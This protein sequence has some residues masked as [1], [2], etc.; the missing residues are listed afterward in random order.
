MWRLCSKILIL[1]SLLTLV[2][3]SICLAKIETKKDDFSGNTTYSSRY[4]IKVKHGGHEQYSFIRGQKNG[5]VVVQ[6]SAL[7]RVMGF[8]SGTFEDIA[9]LRIDG[10]VY[11]ISLLDSKIFREYLREDRGDLVGWYQITDDLLP[12]IADAKEIGM[13]LKLGDTNKNEAREVI[14]VTIPPEIIQEWK[15]VIAKPFI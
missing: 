5:K 15:D 6:L 7:V 14:L 12:K 3:S 9:E 13:R 10:T 4:Y 11:E 2:L 8:G 1:T